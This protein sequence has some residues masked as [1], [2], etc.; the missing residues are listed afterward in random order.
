MEQGRRNTVPNKPQEGR[1]IAPAAGEAMRWLGMRIPQPLY[2]RLKQIA[3]KDQRSVSWMAR[4]I[5]EEGVTRRE[6]EQ[7]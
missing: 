6:Q 2:E 5:L 3:D 4:I 7:A 1:A